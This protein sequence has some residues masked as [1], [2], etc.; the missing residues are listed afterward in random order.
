L[1]QAARLIARGNLAAAMDGLLDILR[2]NKTYRKGLPKEILL[3]L[4]SLLGEGD[5]L[6]REY[7]DELASVLF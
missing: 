7:R 5:T 4:F 6:T 2:Q 3:A 1:D